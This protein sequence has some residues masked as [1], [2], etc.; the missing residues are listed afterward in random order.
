MFIPFFLGFGG[1]ISSGKQWFPWIHVEDVAGIIYYAIQNE[2]VN[3]VLNAT[4]PHYIT[5]AEFTRAFASQL[6]RPAL[7]T[8]PEFAL[9]FVYGSERAQ[10]L[11]TGAKVIPKRTL[12]LG[13]EYLYPDIK[14]A[15]KEFATLAPRV[16]TE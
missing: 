4:A 12:D 11:T 8:V 9:N 10:A 16:L 7:C 2:R 13:Y 14:S 1:K 6:W 5:N 3:G 15:C